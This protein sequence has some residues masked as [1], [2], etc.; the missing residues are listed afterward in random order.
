[1][2]ATREPV[3]VFGIDTEIDIAISDQD[4]GERRAMELANRIRAVAATDPALAQDLV[5]QLIVALDRALGGTFREHLDEPSRLVAEQALVNSP[6]GV[7][8]DVSPLRI[9]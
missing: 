1:M 7:G 9:S 6:N 5:D 3:D 2:T 4:E 8:A